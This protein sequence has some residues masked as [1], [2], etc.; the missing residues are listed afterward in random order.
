MSIRSTVARLLPKKVISS[1]GRLQFKVPLLAPIIRWGAKG[2]TSG[3]GTIK[4]GIGKGLKFDASG[5]FPGY[6]LGTTEIDEQE[7]VASLI[8]PGEVFYD[9]GA[10]VGFY[11]TLVA[12]LVGPLGKVYGFEPFPESAAAA[13]ANAARNG[14]N[15]VKIYEVALSDQSGEATLTTDGASAVFRLDASDRSGG[16]KKTLQVKLST[17]DEI[18]ANENLAGPALVMIDVEGAEF[19][20]LR[21]MKETIRAHRPKILCEVHWLSS[22]DLLACMDEVGGPVKYR[23]E[24]MD[25]KPLSKEIER[26]HVVMRPE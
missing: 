2:V 3:E 19:K 7:L 20:V 25:G 21:G 17:L 14:F 23:V 10:N 9:I 5:G 22:D 12:N 13:R 16:V 1:L 8:K 26:F 18:V 24:R 15:Q 11:T 4:Y 6:A